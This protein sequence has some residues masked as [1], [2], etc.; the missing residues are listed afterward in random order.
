MAAQPERDL[1]RFARD[2]NLEILASMSARLEPGSNQLSTHQ[3]TEHLTGKEAFTRIDLGKN[4]G[5]ARVALRKSAELVENILRGGEAEPILWM[6]FALDEL[7]IP[8]PSDAPTSGRPYNFGLNHPVFLGTCRNP[9]RPDQPFS[10]TQKVVDY[11]LAG[12]E[13]KS[14]KQSCFGICLTQER[15]PN[16]NPGECVEIY[17]CG[18]EFVCS[19]RDGIYGTPMQAWNSELGEDKWYRYLKPYDSLVGS[20]ASEKIKCIISLTSFFNSLR[21]PRRKA[22]AQFAV[23]LSCVPAE[24]NVW[25]VYD[26]LQ[27]VLSG[28]P[29][30]WSA[31]SSLVKDNLDL[32]RYRDVLHLLQRPLDGL[33]KSINDMQADVRL[34]N[35]VLYEP[36]EAIFKTHKIIPDLFEDGKTIR[37]SGSVVKVKH[38]GKY[39]TPEDAVLILAEAVF[40]IVGAKSELPKDQILTKIDSIRNL[41]QTVCDHVTKDLQSFKSL[42]EELLWV[43]FPKIEKTVIDFGDLFEI[44]AVDGIDANLR[45][46]Q[47]KDVLFT[48]FKF[49][50]DKGWNPRALQLALRAHHCDFGFEPSNPWNIPH[51]WTPFAYGVVLDFLMKCCVEYYASVASHN[52]QGFLKKV[53]VVPV[54]APLTKDKGK[55]FEI[56]LYFSDTP[57]LGEFNPELEA[58]NLAGLLNDHVL[59]FPRDWRLD[60]VSLGNFYKPFVDLCNKV[61]RRNERFGWRATQLPTPEDGLYTIVRLKN[62][63]GGNM[64]QQPVRCFEVAL[65]A[66]TAQPGIRLRWSELEMEPPDFRGEDSENQQ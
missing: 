2:A 3:I 42:A 34:L 35:A 51:H 66:K 5:L 27:I 17:M 22:A 52:V 1:L 19:E 28:L 33:S 8:D 36:A 62:C 38:E 46:E 6:S 9:Q 13:A 63:V 15:I 26:L 64:R 44:D 49:I 61:V 12:S 54:Y 55:T 41:K 40:R 10:I 4:A 59:A 14:N 21:D 57:F 37:I 7:R 58:S 53:E 30:A 16:F 24:D 29:M 60:Y 65:G 11:Y 47:L 45:V 18:E 23:A 32:R 31:T 25:R 39:E 20:G 48:P 43:C 50:Q 56:S